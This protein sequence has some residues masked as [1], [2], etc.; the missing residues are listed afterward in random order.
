M[1][2]LSTGFLVDVMRRD[3]PA[4]ELL[5]RL[6][7]GSAAVRLPAIVHAD[8]WEAAGRSRQ[9]P[10]EME[11]VEALLR[12]YAS[13]ALEPRHA[14]RAGT[15]AAKHGLP[16]REALLVATAI[17]ERDELV[18]RDAPRYQGIDGLRILTY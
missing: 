9:P 11:R 12:G 7:R 10:R 18:V 16:L 5:R 17:E 13:V 3:A 2:L 4:L 14:M 8:L 6:E 1:T 15:L